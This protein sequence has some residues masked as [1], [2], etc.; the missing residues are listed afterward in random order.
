MSN[1]IKNITV[2]AVFALF[3]AFFAVMCV[4]NFY[5]PDEYSESERREPSRAG[6]P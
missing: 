6:G 5:N 2:T 3:L 1:K 4:T